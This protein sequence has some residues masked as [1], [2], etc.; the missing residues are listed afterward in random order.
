MNGNAVLVPTSVALEIGGLDPHYRHGMADFDY[1]LRAT[2]AQIPVWLAS[3]W[4]GT[5]AQHPMAGSFKDPSMPT[6]A[7]ARALLSQKGI[8]PRE[9]LRLTYRHAGAGW[10]L[11]FASPYLRF[12]SGVLRQ[13]LASPRRRA[14]ASAG[15]WR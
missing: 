7:R 4:V 8:P 10:P 2:K 12:A 14:R 11:Y 5:C 13:W 6:R 3:G 1:G 9:W 15:D